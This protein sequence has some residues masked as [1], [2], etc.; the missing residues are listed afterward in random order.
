MS[1]SGDLNEKAETSPELHLADWKD[2]CDTVHMWTQIVGKI[3]MKLTPPDNHWWHVPLYVTSRGLTTSTIPYAGGSFEI[4]F[5]FIDHRLLILTCT[6]STRIIKLQPMSVAE[7]YSEL[8]TVLHELGIGVHIF[9]TPSEVPNPIPFDQDTV[10]ASYDPVSIHRFWRILLTTQEVFREFKGRFF[11]K[12]S[13]I[14]FFWG[15]FDLAMTRFSGRRAPDRE[16]ADALT[17]EAYSHEVISCGFW[18]GGGPV[19]D[20]AYYCYSAPVPAGLDKEEIRP[21]AAF[22]SKELGEFLLMYDDVRRSDSSKEF[23]LDFLQSTYNAG[24]KLANWDRAS[25]DRVPPIG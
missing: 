24:A 1:V 23:L 6:G 5:D 21:G 3:R 8:M 17:R 10:H 12:I 20:A 4:C 22:H 7:F 19:N 13:P 15:S 11:G 2:T 16:G 18:P 9:K 25:L 14:H